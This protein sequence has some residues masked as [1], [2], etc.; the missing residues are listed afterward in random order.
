MTFLKSPNIFIVY[1]LLVFSGLNT[2]AQTNY[3]GRS[4]VID[5]DQDLQFSKSWFQAS[6][7]DE[8]NLKLLLTVLKKSQ[9]GIKILE[10]AQTKAY[11]KGETLLDVLRI[12]DGSLTDT[13]LVR[14]FSASDP[15][16]VIYE[17]KSKVYI[18]RHLN[19]LD[20]SLD[21][22]HEL[23]HFTFREAFNPY[24]PKFSMKEFIAGTVEGK[25]GEVDAFLIECKVY[26]ELFPNKNE[27]RSSCAKIK[28]A[29]SGELSRE[30]GIEEFY[31]IGKHFDEFHKNIERYKLAKMD[32]PKVNKTDAQF[33]SSAWGVPYPLAAFREYVNIMDR[34][35]KNDSNRLSLLQQKIGRQ[36][37]SDEVNTIQ[38]TYRTMSEEY[39]GRCQFF[40]P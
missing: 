38:A 12:G 21:L 3:V 28:D 27:N 7:S 13:T 30:K 19:L 32:F 4:K 40:L 29:H 37:A 2:H 16:K 18:N 35:C 33:I 36:P 26:Y 6:K 22:A 31:R 23:T 25:G 10:K 5:V 9:T 1:F 24:V 17:T 15:T 20:A 39:N 11:E 34:V 8:D 14:R